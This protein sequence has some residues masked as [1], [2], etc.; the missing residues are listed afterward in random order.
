MNGGT[1]RRPD[2]PR[3]RRGRYTGPE[4]KQRF[5]SFKTKREAEGWLRDELGKLDRG[6]WADPTR[7]MG[8]YE[9]HAER[10]LE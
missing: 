4:G 5:R 7:G 10:W 9:D 6:T 2:R 1:D 8:H 3:R